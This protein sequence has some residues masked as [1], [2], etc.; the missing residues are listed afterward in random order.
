MKEEAQTLFVERERRLLDAIALKEPD[1]VPVVPLFAFFN[2]FYAGITPREAYVDPQKAVAAWRKTITDFEPDATYSVNFTVYAMDEVLSRL[3]FKAMKWPGHG[4][5]DTQSF[6]FVE[7]EYMMAEEYDL[8]FK[9]PGEYLLRHVL[10]RLAGNLS[11]LAKIPPLETICLGY[12]WPSVLAAFADPTVI[13]A[14]ET[15]MEAAKKQLEWVRTFS[16]FAQE[17]KDLGFP[18]IKEQTVFTAYDMIADNL[19][20]TRGAMMDLFRRP[21]QLK[22]AVE[23]IAPFIT[24]A[25]I[26]GA[27]AK[28]NPRIFIPLHKGT[29]SFM[30]PKQFEAFYWPTLQQ[31]IVDICDAGCTPYLLIEGV[32]DT[33]LEVIKQVPKGKCI[34]HFEGTDIFKAKQVLGDTVCLMGNVPNSLLATG[35]VEDVRNYCKKL[36]DICGAG[37]G[38]IMS[39][40]AIIDEARVENVRT[41]METTRDY[42][43]YHH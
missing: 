23:Q 32:Y 19:R 34:Y 18:S 3:D 15:I 39:S 7:N 40:G 41:M 36:I 43:R 16:N 29:D 35:K 8:F 2:C 37:G 5:P 26:N 6:Q 17:L 11:G 27:K 13:S 4:I 24:A 20:G 33:R 30:S 14:L 22:R 21:A 9:N 25:A 12:A 10:P 42:G 28:G 1:R 38:F 31:L